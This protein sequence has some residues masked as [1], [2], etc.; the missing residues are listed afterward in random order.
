MTRS[1]LDGVAGLGPVRRARLLKEF[2]SVAKLRAMS[3]DELQAIPWLPDAVGEALGEALHGKFTP[4]R[5]EAGA[6]GLGG[7][8]SS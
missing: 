4:E 8:P 2:G 3:V 6:E 5:R 1:V 7:V